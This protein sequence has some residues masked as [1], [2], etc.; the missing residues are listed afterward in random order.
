[1]VLIL[2]I[3]IASSGGSGASNHDLPFDLGT[4]PLP[5]PEPEKKDPPPLEPPAVLEAARRYVRTSPDDLAGQIERFD[6][7]ITELRGNPWLTHADRERRAVL[8][9]FEVE[10]ERAVSALDTET[11]GPLTRGEIEK[12]LEILEREKSRRTG[13]QWQ[14]EISRRIAEVR[15]L[16][17]VA[18]SKGPIGWWI[19]DDAYAVS[20]LPRDGYSEIGREGYFSWLGF[21]ERQVL[22]LRRDAD[23]AEA[24]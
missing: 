15:K 13:T 4:V 6:R 22:M 12:V 14:D 21:E 17:A 1:M 8:E 19:V 18:L 7:A 24:R 3:V 9:R 23:A 20:F 5:P 11:N 10:W 2:I 16:A